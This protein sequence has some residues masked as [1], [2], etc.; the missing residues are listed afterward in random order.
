MKIYKS[1]DKYLMIHRNETIGS[2]HFCFP[3]KINDTDHDVI[4]ISYLV[5]IPQ[6]RNNKIA[7]LLLLSVFMDY[8]NKGYRFVELV[9]ASA[10]YRH[11]KN[12]YKMLGLYYKHY[13]NDMRGNLRHI[14]FGKKIINKL[15]IT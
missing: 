13:D 9:D 3:D 15:S 2:C 1:N 8:Y 14:L 12:I 7:T 6:Y 11:K 10:R 5:V 4:F